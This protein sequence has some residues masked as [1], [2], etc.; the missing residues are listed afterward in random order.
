M[1]AAGAF[2]CQTLSLLHPFLMSHRLELGRDG[3][4][5]VAVDFELQWY[6]WKGRPARDDQG[7][8]A[9]RH[10]VQSANPQRPLMMTLA[11]RSYRSGYWLA[12]ATY[13]STGPERRLLGQC[14]LLC[15]AKHAALRESSSVESH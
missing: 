1:L 5:S 15:W 11:F 3:C 13:C 8:A 12:A 14:L 4:S 7:W 10:S 2:P 6:R 9:P